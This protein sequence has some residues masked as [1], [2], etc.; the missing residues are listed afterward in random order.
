ME[1]GWC[2]VLRRIQFKKVKQMSG[3]IRY[4]LGVR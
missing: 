1:F 3:W 2:G 4:G